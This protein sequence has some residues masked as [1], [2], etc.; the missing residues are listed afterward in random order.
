MI[1]EIDL[2]GVFLPPMV[3]YAA[4]AAVLWLALRKVLTWI[5]IDRFVWHPALFNTAL[6]VL[7]LA[8]CVMA[9]FHWDR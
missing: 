6:Y 9:V 3:A 1:K 4:V 2:F 7:V 8:G 5:G